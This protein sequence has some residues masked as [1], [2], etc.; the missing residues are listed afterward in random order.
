MTVRH[1]WGVYP[2]PRRAWKGWQ[3]LHW[4]ATSSLP[5]PSGNSWPEAG[6]AAHSRTAVIENRRNFLDI[7]PPPPLP[8]HDHSRRR[9]LIGAAIGAEGSAKGTARA[10]C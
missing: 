9:H 8:R 6:N 10:R 1:P 7:V 2:P 5:G 3:L 4:A